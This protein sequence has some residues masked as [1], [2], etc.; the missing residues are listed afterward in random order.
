MSDKE[1]IAKHLYRVGKSIPEI[2]QIVK[3]NE[4]IVADIFSDQ[5]KVLH[6]RYIAYK[7]D[8]KLTCE[9]M[10]EEIKAA[11][12]LLNLKMGRMVVNADGQRYVE[13]R[14]MKG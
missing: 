4:S 10:Y 3:L 14:K 6:N 5:D 13:I 1:I 11:V 7:K 9:I 12:A 2:S 8:K